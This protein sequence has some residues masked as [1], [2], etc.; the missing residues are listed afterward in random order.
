[1]KK[2][3]PVQNNLQMNQS[4]WTHFW[5][6]SSSRGVYCSFQYSSCAHQESSWVQWFKSPSHVNSSRVHIPVLWSCC[7]HMLPRRTF[8]SAPSSFSGTV[9]TKGSRWCQNEVGLI[10]SLNAVNSHLLVNC[11]LEIRF[12]LKFSWIIAFIAFLPGISQLY[13]IDMKLAAICLV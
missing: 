12:P 11:A 13:T 1:M 3:D 6:N 2:S 5:W 10:F 4:Y 8:I 7:N 9:V